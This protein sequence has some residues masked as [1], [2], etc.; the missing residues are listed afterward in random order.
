MIK[1]PNKLNI[2]GDFLNISKGIC[3]KTTANEI[4]NGERLDIFPI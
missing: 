1:T 4:F 3:K 2:E